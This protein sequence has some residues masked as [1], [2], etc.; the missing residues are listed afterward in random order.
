MTAEEIIAAASARTGLAGF[1]DPAIPEL[2]E[3]PAERPMFVFGLP[4]AGVRAQFRDYVE[5]FAI[6]LQ[7]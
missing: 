7:D 6:P 5:G 2:P 3:R 1:G 4:Q